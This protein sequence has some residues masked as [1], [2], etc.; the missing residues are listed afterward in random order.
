MYVSAAW[1]IAVL[2]VLLGHQQLLA[3]Q[4]NSG[5]FPLV[6]LGVGAI[7][8]AIACSWVLV[9]TAAFVISPQV[10]RKL[11]PKFVVTLVI[12]GSALYVS[13]AYAST[14]LDGLRL[15]E[16]VTFEPVSAQESNTAQPTRTSANE[17]YTVQTG[18]NLWRIAAS[19]L[20][21]TATPAEI[22]VE[23]NRWHKQNREIIGVDPDRLFPGQTLTSP[24]TD[25]GTN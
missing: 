1:S 11:G 12:G 10:A 3:E 18:D 5:R 17:T 23:M 2:I 25:S 9:I 6:L 15:P 19:Q 14:D 13:P 22:A 21:P 16:R 4:L 24:S 8:V 7:V 20:P